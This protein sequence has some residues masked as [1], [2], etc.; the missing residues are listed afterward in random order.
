M[1]L[2]LTLP[3]DRRAPRTARRA[4]RAIAWFLPPSSTDDVELLANELVT[5]VIRHSGLRPSQR[6]EVRAAASPARVRVEVVGGGRPF[7]PRT[8]PSPDQ[9]SGWGLFLV[10][11]LSSRWGYYKNAGTAVWFEID[12]E[13]RSSTE[14]LP[15][16]S[17]E[18]NGGWEAMG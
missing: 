9:T 10:G 11:A 4:M 6:M 12:Q 18:A 3:A 7:V 2:I 13:R 16:E 14:P 17:I 1:E 8:Q 15:P 5:N